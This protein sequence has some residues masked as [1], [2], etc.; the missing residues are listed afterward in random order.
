LPSRQAAGR[1]GSARE[2]ALALALAH[3]IQFPTK[4]FCSW[5]RFSDFTLSLEE[6]LDINKVF[7]SLPDSI[8]S[9]FR[10]VRIA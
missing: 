8:V 7:L 1:E 5:T 9:F 4:S 6:A 10:K 2:Q 3:E